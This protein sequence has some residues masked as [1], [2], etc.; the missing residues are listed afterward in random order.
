MKKACV[1]GHLGINKDLSNGQTIKTKIIYNELINNFGI[2][3]IDYI[4][5]YN[6][7]KKMFKLFNNIL[8]KSS[9]CDNIIIMP[10]HNGVRIFIPIFLFLKKIFHF[11]LHYIVIGGW[12][13]TFIEKHR[14]L[15]RMLGK[16]D[17]IYVETKT[18]KEKLKNYDNI[19]ILPNCKSIKLLNLNEIKCTYNKPY[20]LCVFSRIMR[21]K[22]IEDAIE[23]VKEINQKSGS[24]LYELDI[25]GQ[26]DTKQ[27]EWFE[28]LKKDF[29]SYIRY[30]GVVNYNNTTEVLKQYFLL[31]F[32][33][34]FYT[35]GIPGTIIDSYAA[36]LPVIASKWES[37]ND[38]IDDGKTGIGYE[39]ENIDQFKEILRNISEEEVI[40]M[41]ENC[42]KK[43]ETF[44][45]DNVIKILINNLK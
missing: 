14:Y 31:L 22:G 6:W 44:R 30:C 36:G 13:P 11:K 10:A 19:I 4:D 12:L 20:K 34:K 5:T 35:E 1:V 32:P 27:T 16:I 7:K 33:T 21:E 29:P 18:M 8:K 37:F 41:K 26:I 2:D 40:T 3:N 43:A 23:I 38:V 17:C 9:I 15:K 42:L 28:I 45:T 24:I 25:Y 39:F